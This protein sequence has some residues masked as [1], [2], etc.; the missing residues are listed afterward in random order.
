MLKWLFHFLIFATSSG[1]YQNK[2]KR[3]KRY[4]D[5]PLVGLFCKDSLYFIMYSPELSLSFLVF[6]EMSWMLRT[7]A[8]NEKII[9]KIQKNTILLQCV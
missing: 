2:E 6:P 3:L 1:K 9:K 8:L 4:S 7:V 5:Y